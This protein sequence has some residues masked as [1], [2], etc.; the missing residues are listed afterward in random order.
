MRFTA[1]FSPDAFI[2]RSYARG[3]LNINGVVHHD[4]LLLSA[5]GVTPL[6]GVPRAAD[7]SLLHAEAVLATAPQI[8]LV[9]SP[10]ADDWPSAQWRAYF[11]SR[12]IGL[13]VMNSGAACRTYTVL[14]SERRP[15]AAVLLP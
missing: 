10:H 4:P 2:I 15:V 14:T 9:G 1:D 5:A 12:G 3:A 8:V 13:E 7:L 6:S 11:L